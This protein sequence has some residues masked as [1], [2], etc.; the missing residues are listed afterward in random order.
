MSSLDNSKLEV[1]CSQHTLTQYASGS[2]AERVVG[3]TGIVLCA[4]GPTPLAGPS[5]GHP[6]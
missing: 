6:V 5:S 1:R 4:L 3:L 2:S